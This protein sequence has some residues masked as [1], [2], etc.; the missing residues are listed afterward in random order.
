MTAFIH[1]APGRTPAPHH[2]EEAFRTQR[3]SRFG[4]LRSRARS[5]PGHCRD[6]PERQRPAGRPLGYNVARAIEPSQGDGPG[7]YPVDDQDEDG[8]IT[9]DLG[10]LIE[11]GGSEAAVQ[12]L[13]ERYYLRLVS[14]A[15][16][17]LQA[18]PRQVAD[19]ED[20]ALSAFD[21]FCRGAATGRFPKLG[22]RHDLWRLLVTITSRKVA[23]QI[24]RERAGKRD[25]RRVRDEASLARRAPGGDPAA[26]ADGVL[27]R[28]VGRE[29]SPEFAAAMAEQFQSLIDRLRDRTLREVALLKM[30]GYQ[31][32]DIARRMNCSLR[33]IERK[34]GLIRKTW[35]REGVA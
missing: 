33:S 30:E 21:S 32:E 24:E 25:H 17:R 28:V 10:A 23:D 1:A 2:R 8:S 5:D 7:A 34:L 18:A 19:E 4:I 11:S 35:Q 14:L 15:R 27:A 9:R 22:S 16:T 29:P 26:R 12:S 20:V 3:A 6:G 31:N 13:W